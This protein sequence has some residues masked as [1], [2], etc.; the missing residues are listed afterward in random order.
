[1]TDEKIAAIFS[2]INVS[3]FIQCLSDCQGITGKEAMELLYRM[4]QAGLT[5]SVSFIMAPAI[6][7]KSIPHEEA[8]QSML[9]AIHGNDLL[10]DGTCI[11]VKKYDGSL[12]VEYLSTLMIDREQASQIFSYLGFK[13]P[14]PW[15]PY[16]IQANLLKKKKPHNQ[17]KLNEANNHRQNA[18]K[19]IWDEWRKEADQIQ[20]DS[21]ITLSKNELAKRVK[22]R[23]NLTETSGTIRKRL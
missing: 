13:E 20:S 7:E 17:L 5:L 14:C 15:P 22:K 1:M 18:R 23:L 9:S 21:S 19:S 6:P 4:V 11:T 2:S 10:A 8:E 3:H 12:W 16:Q